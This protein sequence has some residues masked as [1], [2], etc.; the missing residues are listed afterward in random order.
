[1]IGLLFLQ[2]G[3]RAQE[4]HAAE[5][6]VHNEA[7][8]SSKH[9][10]IS[11]LVS[12]T[13]LSEGVEE[14]ENKW[15]IV[16]SFNINYNF[17]FHPK[18]AIGLHTDIIIEEFE[19]EEHHVDSETVLKRSNPVAPAI[20]VTYKPL[21]WLGIEIGPGMEFTK[22][23]DFALMRLGAEFSFHASHK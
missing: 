8:T 2:F 6:T 23:E 19:V 1:M 10:V 22:E 20:M 7:H 11:V 14:G 13:H 9:H 18:W 21:T 5:H 4:E 17:V 12:H 16:P 15:L 3:L